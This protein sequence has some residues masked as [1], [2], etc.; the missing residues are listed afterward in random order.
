MLNIQTTHS[1]KAKKTRSMQVR[2]NV[3]DKSLDP[4]AEWLRMRNV[5]ENKLKST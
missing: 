5:V 4:L 1:R 2:K 3:K